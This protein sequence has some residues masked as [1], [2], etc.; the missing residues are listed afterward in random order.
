LKQTQ[1]GEKILIYKFI[2][3]ALILCVYILGKGL[4]LYSIDLSEYLHKTMDAEGLLLQ[5]ISGDVLQCSI[6]ALGV[7]PYMISSMVAQIISAFR[8]SESKSKISPVKMNRVALA[9][10][11]MIAIAQAVLRVM[12]LKF[13]VTGDAL[14]HAQI[15]AGVEMVAGAMIIIWLCSRNKKYGI[16]GQTALIYVNILDGIFATISRGDIKKLALPLLISGVVILV[17]VFME[18][19]EMRIPLQRISIHNI[20]ADKNY[21]AIKFNPIGVMPAMFSMAFFMV[22]Q[23]VVTALLFSD[24]LNKDYWW[25]FSNMSLNKPLGISIYIGAVYV[26][27]LGFS[28]VFVNPKELTEQ[29]LKSG[30]SVLGIHAGKDTRKYISRV[31]NRLGFL[32]ATVMSVCLGVPMLLQLQGYI[33][34]A[35][36]ML[37]SSIMMMTGIWCNLHREIQAVK[38]LEGYKP[39]I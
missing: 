9:L 12:E 22:P 5:T 13:S 10:A 6:F 36:V 24:P 20:Y 8:S 33:D 14:L 17:M 31:I 4:P 30:D 2:Y 15:I 18:N 21:L 3:T 7:S 23:M 32:S 34:S 19:A 38:D 16:G 29:F 1:K 28:R 37:P 35:Y 39:F 27:T 26:L 25:W 11:L